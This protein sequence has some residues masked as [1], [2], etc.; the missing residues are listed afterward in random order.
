MMPENK[1]TE[2]QLKMFTTQHSALLGVPRDDAGCSG[3]DDDDD[4]DFVVAVL[5]ILVS[6]VVGKISHRDE[7]SSSQVIEFDM[8][9]SNCMS[10]KGLVSMLT[11]R[12]IFAIDYSDSSS[13]REI[14]TKFLRGLKRSY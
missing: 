5:L 9:W 2:R 1:K 11:V 13:N 6:V 12:T 8:I 14:G 10:L 4:D 3:C 7:L